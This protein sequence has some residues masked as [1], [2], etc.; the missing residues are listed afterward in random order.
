MDKIHGS[1]YRTL[2]CGPYIVRGRG[3][4]QSSKKCSVT[5]KSIPYVIVEM[6][7]SS[8]AKKRKHGRGSAN[9][10]L[11]VLGVVERNGAFFSFPGA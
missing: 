11:W 1:T 2:H 8:F 5:R 6:D 9:D 3:R 7:E 10:T 4:T